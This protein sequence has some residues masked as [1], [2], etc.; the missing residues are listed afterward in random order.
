MPELDAIQWTLLV[1]LRVV[2]G[3]FGEWLERIPQT[4]FNWLIIILAVAASIRLR[5]S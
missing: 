1:G 3:L 5:L 4:L 2:R